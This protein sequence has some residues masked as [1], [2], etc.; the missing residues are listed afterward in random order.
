LISNN[1]WA[2]KH[3][4]SE[5]N[6]LVIRMQSG[7]RDDDMARIGYAIGG[8]WTV[9]EHP[10]TGGSNRDY[11]RLLPRI[12]LVAKNIMWG[13]GALPASHNTYVNAGRRAGIMGWIIMGFL[14]WMLW[15]TGRE[16]A[17][18]HVPGEMQHTIRALWAA[19]AAVL[20]NAFFHNSGILAAEPMTWAL[21][22]LCLGGAV[23][24]RRLRCSFAQRPLAV[25]RGRVAVPSRSIPGLNNQNEVYE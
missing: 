2:I 24:D 8:I 20:L 25:G 22:S 21:V 5:R 9:I 17:R 3:Q 19:L 15:R 1:E 13:Y 4:G 16:A 14:L 7:E 10:L 23:L 11:Q 12:P 18:W 6:N